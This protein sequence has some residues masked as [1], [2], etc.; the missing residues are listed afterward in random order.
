M[1]T[2]LPILLLVSTTAVMAE[3]AHLETAQDMVSCVPSYLNAMEMASNAGLDDM[4][5]QFE[6]SARGAL[7]AAEQ[8]LKNGGYEQDW[9]DTVMTD[10]AE[11]YS[12]SFKY[13]NTEQGYFQSEVERCGPLSKTQ[14]TLV[15]QWRS[16][17]KK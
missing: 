13:R 4:A 7:I 16:E 17:N 3:D 2:L 15:N 11:S 9:I 5:E 1:K 14:T 10:W 8:S 12:V 6:G